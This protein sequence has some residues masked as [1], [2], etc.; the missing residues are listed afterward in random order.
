VPDRTHLHRLLVISERLELARP[1]LR[2]LGRSLNKPLQ[3][4]LHCIHVMVLPERARGR[5]LQ[6][7]RARR[8]KRSRESCALVAEARRPASTGG[9][10]RVCGGQIASLVCGADLGFGVVLEQLI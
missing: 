4:P 8:W 3:L 5:F 10:A 6:E 7:R 2:L 1:T 9:G